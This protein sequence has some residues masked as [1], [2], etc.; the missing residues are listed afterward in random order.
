MKKGDIVVRKISYLP[1][2]IGYYDRSVS[3]FSSG[4]LHFIDILKTI[5]TESNFEIVYPNEFQY[6][7]DLDLINYINIL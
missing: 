1:N 5:N 2:A 7:G 6:I 4:S 3:G